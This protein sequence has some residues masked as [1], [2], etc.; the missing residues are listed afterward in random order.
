MSKRWSEDLQ[1]Q[2]IALYQEYLEYRDGKLYWKK[3]PSNAAK[4]DV[5]VGKLDGGY[6]RFFFKGKSHRVHRVVWMMH[7]GVIPEGYEIDHLYHDKEDNRIEMLR[8]VRKIDNGRNQSKHAHN[9]SGHTG[10]NWMASM[11]KWR[12][13]IRIDNKTIYLGCYDEIE[14]A[15]RA[16]QRA[17]AERGFHPN[18][19]K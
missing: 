6:L 7:N 15:I 2:F 11:Q 13:E 12:A 4:M 3:R 8:C 5:P 9:T 17:E 16:R 1:L 19:G 10:V 18:H 14:E